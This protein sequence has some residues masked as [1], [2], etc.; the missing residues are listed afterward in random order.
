MGV[1]SQL[2]V[3]G[4]FA[5]V[6]QRDGRARYGADVPRFC[7]YREAVRARRPELG[8]LKDLLTSLGQ[9]E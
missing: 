2:E 4:I 1:Q 8:E 6:C 3:I 7:S 5:R 9:P